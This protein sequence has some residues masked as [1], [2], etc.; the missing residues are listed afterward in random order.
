M[1]NLQ[2]P[3]YK[4]SMYKVQLTRIPQT[5]FYEQGSMNK[6]LRIRTAF[7]RQSCYSPTSSQGR[8]LVGQASVVAYLTRFAV[9]FISYNLL[10]VRKLKN[11]YQRAT[12]E[13]NFLLFPQPRILFLFMSSGFLMRPISLK[14]WLLRPFSTKKPHAKAVP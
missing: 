14:Y 13:D 5:R 11:Y 10:N 8:V 9:K 12:Y 7:K 4:N 1:H 3:I 2:I 6:V